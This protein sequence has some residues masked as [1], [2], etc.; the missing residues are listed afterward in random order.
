MEDDATDERQVHG[1]GQ[2]DRSEDGTMVDDGDCL[3][4]E[5]GCDGDSS[6]EDIFSIATGHV[7]EDFED[8]G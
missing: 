3:G 1:E 2:N 5:C 4:V 6:T 8:D 7:P